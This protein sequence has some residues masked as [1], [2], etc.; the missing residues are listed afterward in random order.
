VTHHVLEARNLA[1]I[2]PDGTQAL[3][4]VS[5]TIHHGES[6]GIVGPNG[7]GKSTLVLLLNGCLMPTDGEV[8]LGDRVLSKRNRKEFHRRVGVVFQNPEDQLF[9]PTVREDVAFGPQCQGLAPDTVSERCDRAM[10]WMGIT[11][12]A[13]K[14][15][16]HLSEGQ[17]KAV[18]IAGVLAMEPDVLV[19]D[20]PSAGLDPASRR[21]LIRFCAGYHH[22]RIIVS[23]DLDFVL[24]TCERCL[25]LDGGRLV[26]DAPSAELLENETL[27]TRHRLEL[28]RMLQPVRR[29]SGW[30]PAGT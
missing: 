27:L 30:K 23:H 20:E 18:A 12:V 9:L 8:R 4:K 28:P 5:F 19:L 2:Y 1:F 29:R 11:E 13:D 14:P 25:L 3:R 22:T 21:E 10:E 7:A 16:H 24:E 6:V 17:R 15:P 26:A